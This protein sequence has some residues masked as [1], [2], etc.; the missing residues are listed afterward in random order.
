MQGFNECGV[1]IGNEA[2]FQVHGLDYAGNSVVNFGGM[3]AGAGKFTRLQGVGVDG[4][5]R[6]FAV[7]SFQSEVR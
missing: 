3:G 7:D 5:G 2:V 6:I 1:A 4:E